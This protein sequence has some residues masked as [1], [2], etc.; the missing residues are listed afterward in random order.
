MKFRILKLGTFTYI[1]QIQAS[2]YYWQ[3]ISKRNEYTWDME[4]Q[5][6]A[7]CRHYTLFGAKSTIRKHI[8]ETTKEQTISELFKNAKV[9]YE[10]ETDK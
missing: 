3:G 10:I 6:M 1:P 9:V 7:F 2:K 4:G 5:Q 8:K